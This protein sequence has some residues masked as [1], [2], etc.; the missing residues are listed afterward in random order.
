MLLLQVPPMNAR[1]HV[2]TLPPT[3]AHC[4]LDVVRMGDRVARVLPYATA[5]V[6]RV[7]REHGY[8]PH[9]CLWQADHVVPLAEGGKDVPENLQRLCQPCHKAK[10]T[11]QARRRARRPLKLGQLARLGLL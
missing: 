4:G 2:A 9:L 8:D 3:C 5:E 7:L 1:K 10:T 6:L 11:N